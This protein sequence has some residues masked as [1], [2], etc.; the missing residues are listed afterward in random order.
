VAARLRL[1]ILAVL[2]LGVAPLAAAPSAAAAED[3]LPDLKMSGLYNLQIERG[4]QGNFKLRFGTIVWNVGD[5]PLDVKAGNRID[6]VMHDVAQVIHTRGGPS[7][8]YAPPGATAFYAGDGHD[9][10]HI[11]TFIVIALFPTF[12]VG[13]TT[14]DRGPTYS[15]RGLRKIGFCLTDLVRAPADLRPSNSVNRIGF[16]VRGCGV[17][18]SQEVRMGISVGFGDD[19][20]PFF[21]HQSV[22]ITGL[23]SGPYRLCATVNPTG[24]WLEKD[25]DHVNNS[26]WVDIDLDNDAHRFR[27]VEMGETD[28]D[29]PAPMVYGIGG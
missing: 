3:L 17:E 28:C 23:P 27:V 6:D 10:W 21:N 16:P 22:D 1:V 24:V 25:A 20:K 18:S 9:H 4:G 14:A 5:G 7:R 29:K 19:Y 2:A 26:S 8:E 12:E 11:S 13:A 15:Q